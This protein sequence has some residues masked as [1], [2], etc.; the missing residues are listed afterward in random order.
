M[1]V[2]DSNYQIVYRGETMTRLVSGGWVFFQR[3]KE[4]GDGYWMGKAFED[5][6]VLGIE[7]PVSLNDGLRYQMVVASAAKHPAFN[8]DFELS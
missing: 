8:N 1:D 3:L 7:R 2:K 6:F 5:F 4:Y